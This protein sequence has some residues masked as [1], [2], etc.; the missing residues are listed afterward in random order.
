MQPAGILVLG[1][2]DCGGVGTYRTF[3]S[4]NTIGA[5]QWTDGWMSARM[6]PNRPQVVQCVHCDRA[7][8][9]RDS[10]ILERFSSVQVPESAPEEWRRA[11]MVEAPDE[12][13]YY[14]AIREGLGRDPERDLELRTLAWH[15]SNH[16]YRERAEGL[17]PP[18]ESGERWDNL[19]AMLAL[20][21]H[22][23]GRMALQ[24][25]E[26]LRQLGRWQESLAALDQVKEPDYERF[27][28]AIRAGCQAGN[29][30]VIELPLDDQ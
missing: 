14:R 27:V 26:V 22:G 20:L 12:Q 9:I 24:K 18:P 23:E 29:Q 11:A 8:W 10:E 30:L 17:T 5:R 25:A 13:G 6:M 21:E 19:C 7:H 16:P 4:W 3:G 15:V 28:L 1:C 2:P